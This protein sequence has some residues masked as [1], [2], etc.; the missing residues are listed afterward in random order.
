MARQSARENH[1]TAIAPLYPGLAADV[2]DGTEGLGHQSAR[3]SGSLLR[4]CPMIKSV[5]Y[6][7]GV[8]A[9]VAAG[10]TTLAIAALAA[11]A[12]GSGLT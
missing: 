6:A 12:V 3:L 1:A 7:A 2:T 9:I 4:R 10:M 5:R 11:L 8:V